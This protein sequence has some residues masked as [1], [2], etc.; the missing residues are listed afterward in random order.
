MR[1]PRIVERA[2][3]TDSYAFF[4]YCP[5]NFHLLPRLGSIRQYLT[6]HRHC[7]MKIF[8]ITVSII[9]VSLSG[10]IFFSMYDYLSPA[11]RQI[12]YSTPPSSSENLTVAFIG[13]SWAAMHNCHDNQLARLI[14]SLLPQT[15][16]SIKVLS[17]GKGGAKSKAIYYN[18][19]QNSYTLNPQK[20]QKCT[21][22]IIEQAPNYCIIS[23]GIND[24]STKVGTR[25][26]AGNMMLIIRFLL[27]NDIKPVV[28]EIPRFDIHG[29]YNRHRLTTKILRRIS[30]TLTDSKLDCIDD[31]RSALKDSLRI[32]NIFQ[33]ILYITDA[34]WCPNGYKDNLK[35]YSSDGVHPNAK[36]FL[37]LDSCLS[38]VIANDFIQNINIEAQ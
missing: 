21:Q 10:Y 25:F 36:G 7:I 30:M 16:S 28:I 5:D 31:Y 19:F 32:G 17:S 37:S 13:D 9:I 8:K 26:Y 34:D 4:L 35:Y 20:Y 18:I 3:G 22:S 14:Q 38:K 33:H 6:A 24:A 27:Q 2:T 15:V 12:P 29:T 23:A 1:R 11:S